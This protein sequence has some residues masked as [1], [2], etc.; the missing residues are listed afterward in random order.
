MSQ[1]TA[2]AVH[3]LLA[4][5]CVLQGELA[6]VQQQLSDQQIQC[7]ALTTENAMLQQQNTDAATTINKL[8]EQ[9]QQVQS[10]VARVQKEA[11]GSLREASSLRMQLSQQVSA[12]QELQQAASGSGKELQVRPA[13]TAPS[14]EEHAYNAGSPMHPWHVYFL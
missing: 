4:T 7:Q 14:G 6:S 13:R 1:S 10:D 9:L 11:E 3:T 8:R 12:M 2:A 5:L